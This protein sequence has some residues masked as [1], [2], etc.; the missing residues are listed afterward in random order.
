MEKHMMKVNF[1]IRKKKGCRIFKIIDK[2]Y[3]KGRQFHAKY[4]KTMN[5]KS[6]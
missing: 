6:I 4:S 3:E 5:L 1:G 2:T